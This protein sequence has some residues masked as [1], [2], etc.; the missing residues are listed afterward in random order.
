MAAWDSADCLAKFQLDLN[1]PNSQDEI[2][3]AAYYTWLSRGQDQVVA[4]IA[5]RFPPCL[6]G[7][8]A[9]LTTA[10]NKVFTFGTDPNG[11]PLAPIGK[12]KI[13]PSLSAI[14]DYPL[15]EG[16]D[17]LQENKQI[18][19]P[20]DQQYT[21]GT[22]YWRGI[23]PP[24]VINGT[25]KEPSLFPEQ[26]RELIIAKAMIIFGRQGGLRPDLVAMGKEWW[27]EAFPRWMLVWR[28]QYRS[29]GAL[30]GASG[31]KL[32]EVGSPV[33]GFAG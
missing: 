6:L 23:T 18:R 21:G 7:P 22:L 17:Y 8:P 31:L 13:Y 2:S 1:R 19:I 25:G 12:V 26:S 24:D 33:S 10:D 3:T 32:A 16:Y 28:G 11:Y 15:I 14:P 29:G 20:N 9:A 4:E 30:R 5:S 27:A